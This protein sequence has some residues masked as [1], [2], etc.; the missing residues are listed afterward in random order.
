M[1]PPGTTNT[2]IVDGDAGPEESLAFADEPVLDT[3]ASAPVKPMTVDISPNAFPPTAPPAPS[4][5]SMNDPMTPPAV[6][7]S[8]GPS[9]AFSY[10]PSVALQPRGT[11]FTNSADGAVAGPPPAPPVPHFTISRKEQAKR[12]KEDKED[13]D[14]ERRLYWTRDLFDILGVEGLLKYDPN[15]RYRLR[16]NE[17]TRRQIEKDARKAAK[18]ARRKAR[19]GQSWAQT[20]C[21]RLWGYDA[22]KG[23]AGDPGEDIDDQEVA[24]VELTDVA[25]TNGAPPPA[26][27]SA[28]SSQQGGEE[29]G[30]DDTAETSKLPFPLNLPLSGGTFL[31][32]AFTS[33]MTSSTNIDED[34]DYQMVLEVVRHEA[35]AAQMEDLPSLPTDPADPEY[36]TQIHYYSQMAKKVAHTPFYRAACCGMFPVLWPAWRLRLRR[37]LRDPRFSFVA[38]MWSLL[39]ALTIITSVAT[40]VLESVQELEA[41]PTWRAGLSWAA[42]GCLFIFT[43]ELLL[44]WLTMK[45]IS[46]FFTLINLINI[47][48]VFPPAL[49]AII[50]LIYLDIPSSGSNDIGFT[51]LSVL[52]HLLVLRVFKLVDL[53]ARSTRMSLMFQAVRSSGDGIFSLIIVD[54]ILMIFFSTIVFCGSSAS[55]QMGKIES[56]AFISYP[57]MPKL[58][59]CI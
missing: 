24:P 42:L 27:A 43:V 22:D 13:E 19:E 1:N 44:T 51:I 58:R 33:T 40:L 56:Y 29:A 14:W 10:A 35:E 32:D 28:A 34:M 50:R 8:R 59:A 23:P 7:I 41:N 18:E 37:T 52:Q 25:A 54:F 3:G 49:V 36:R 15:N 39:M 4:I 20:L 38:N 31:R 47:L 45:N 16:K 26:A 53:S 55:E 12:E 11:S 9:N 48:T 5:Q 2:D 6:P 30:A 21:P 57:Q 17:V 46:E